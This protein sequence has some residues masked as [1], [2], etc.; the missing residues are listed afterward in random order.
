MELPVAFQVVNSDTSGFSCP[1]DFKQY[2]VR[3]HL[4]GPAAALASQSPTVT[5]YLYGF[6]GGEF[7]WRMT[8]ALAGVSGYDWALEMAKLGHVSLTIDMLGYDS[9]VTPDGPHGFLNCIGSQADITHQI[10]GQLRNG[11][12]S[13]SGGT[14]N[15]TEFSKVVLAGHDVG[16]HVAEIEAYSYEDINGLMLVT[17]ADQ[18][19]TPYIIEKNT[20]AASDWCT[21]STSGYVHYVTEQEYRT[22]LFY[23]ADPR[24]IDATN[25]L[26]NENPCGIIRSQ[27]QGV[28]VDRANVSRIKVPVLV[29]FGDNEQLVWTRQGEEEQQGDF[30]GSSDKSTVFIPEAR[31]FPMFERTVHTFDSVMS[32]WLASRFQT[33]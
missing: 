23:N 14:N 15:G 20:L 6:E 13:V 7:H 25:A 4:V 33:P 2:T 11:Q 16:G 26:R 17:W 12:Y 28:F 19:F 9:S 30:T 31:H 24:V 1:S 10:V 22:L 3:G 5:F 29:V 18:G 8:E 21:Q 27:P 32:G